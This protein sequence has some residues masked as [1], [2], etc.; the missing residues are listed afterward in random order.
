MAGE[1]PHGRQRPFDLPH[2]KALNCLF[3]L[4][5]ETA[6]RLREMYTLDSAQVAIKDRTIFL[7]KTKNGDKRQVPLSSVAVATLKHYRRKKACCFPGGMERPTSVNWNEPRA[8]C[9]A[10]SH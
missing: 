6:M 8:C 1:K 2:Q 9:R 5:L 7:D 4:A 3:E 10:S